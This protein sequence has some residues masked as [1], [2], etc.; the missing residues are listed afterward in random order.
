MMRE[1]TLD[2]KKMTSPAKA[3]AYLRD[4]LDFPDYYGENLD[5]LHDCLGDIS[6][7]TLIKIPKD[8][9]EGKRLGNF[10]IRLV[11]VLRVAAEENSALQLRII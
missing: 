4:V 10:G 9:A 5:A 3:H 2:V 8:I 1:I 6:E 7:P 11:K